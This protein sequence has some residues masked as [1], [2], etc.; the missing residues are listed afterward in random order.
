MIWERHLTQ[1]K[2]IGGLTSNRVVD[3]DEPMQRSIFDHW[4]ADKNKQSKMETD[5]KGNTERL[6]LHQHMRMGYCK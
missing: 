1:I 6:I 5:V 2:K 3:D 4:L